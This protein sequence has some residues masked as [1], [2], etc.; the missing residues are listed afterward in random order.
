MERTTLSRK[1]FYVYFRDHSELIIALVR[2]LRAQA[3]ASLAQWAEAADPV[4]RAVPRCAPP[5]DFTASTARSCAR[6][7]GRQPMIPTWPRPAAT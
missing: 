3:D 6:C 2:P 4:A 5:P 1:S 7:S